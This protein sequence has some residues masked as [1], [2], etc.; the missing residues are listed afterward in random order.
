M[1][2]LFV[3]HADVIDLVPAVLCHGVEFVQHRRVLGG[4]AVFHH[5][6]N[7]HNISLHRNPKEGRELSPQA[8]IRPR[9]SG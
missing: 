9:I 1:V 5:E 6:C 7:F 4:L 2:I 8:R 3:A